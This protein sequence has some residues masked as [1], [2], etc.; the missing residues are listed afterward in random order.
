MVQI[1]I[2]IAAYNAESTIAETIN[3]V[4][5]QTFSNFE[6]III[7]DGSTDNTEQIILSF[8][9]TRIIYFLQENKGQSAANNFGLSKVN[10]DYIKFFDADDVMNSTHIEAQFEKIKFSKTNLASCKWGRFYNGD[11]VNT[12]F[13]SEL[14]WKDLATLDWLKISLSQRHDMMGGW[15]WLIPKEIIVK[16]GGWDER[17]S[18]NNDFEFSVRMLLC[19][20]KVLFADNAIL[21]Y[22]TGGVNTLA[23][24]TSVDSYNAAYLS[25]F[26]GCTHL[27]ATENSKALRRLCAN[28]FQGWVFAIYPDYLDIVEKFE[29]QIKIWGG[30]DIK[31]QGGNTFVLF[32]KIVGWKTAKRI[33]LFFYRYR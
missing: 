7:N 33:K 15:L 29:R 24:S 11:L 27:L 13:V 3:S 17:L 1:S 28:R 22:R 26:L 20:E 32:S 2:I 14:V 18:L 12:L 23:Q 16:A 31:I 9:D 25:N 21:Y 19:A 8:F 6:L 10:G 4:L 5:T 30:S